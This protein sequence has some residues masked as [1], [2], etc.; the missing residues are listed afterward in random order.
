MV[1]ETT[2]VVVVDVVA[3]VSSVIMVEFVW[4]CLN[5]ELFFICVDVKIKKT[6]KIRLK[7]L[8]VLALFSH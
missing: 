8:L 7:K 3:G 5:S 2:T 4:M 6:K 1:P